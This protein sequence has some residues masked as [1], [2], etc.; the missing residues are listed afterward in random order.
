MPKTPEEL[1]AESKELPGD[2]NTGSHDDENETPP[3]DVAAAAVAAIQPTGNDEVDKLVQAALAEALPKA[4]N[5]ALAAQKEQTERETAERLAKQQGDYEKLYK[6]A[7]EENKV[8][9][10]NQWRGEALQEA[11]LDHK[12]FDSIQGDTKEAMVANAKRFK[13][14]LDADAQKLAEQLVAEHPGT[15]RG[16]GKAN[17]S[18]NDKPSGAQKTQNALATAFGTHRL[19]NV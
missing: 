17:R 6:A 12:W 4:L 7:Q 3:V 18:R 15:P 16:S 1:E 11:G 19:R 13:K 8:L 9:K 2:D 5:A 10:L 14:Q